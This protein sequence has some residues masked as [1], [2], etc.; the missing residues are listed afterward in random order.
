MLFDD[1]IPSQLSK[2]PLKYFSF[3]VAVIGL[4]VG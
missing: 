3:V 2:Q 1:R 4:L